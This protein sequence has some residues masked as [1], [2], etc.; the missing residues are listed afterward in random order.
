MKGKNSTSYSYSSY[1]AMLEL[2]LE[3]RLKKEMEI[4]VGGGVRNHDDYRYFLGK[5][6][7]LK[8]LAK[9]IKES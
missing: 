9:F 6:H 3:R 1:R 4:I 5:V 7:A 8:E 2:E